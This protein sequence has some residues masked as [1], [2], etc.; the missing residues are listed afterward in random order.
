MA[1]GRLMQRVDA[2]E[3]QSGAGFAGY[4]PV[5]VMCGQTLDQ[6][7]AEWEAENGPVGG[8]QWVIW[9]FGGLDEAA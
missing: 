7:K 6:A 1:G 8:R 3:H 9:N 2:L 4:A 5:M